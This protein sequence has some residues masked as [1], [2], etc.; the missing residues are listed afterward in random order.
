MAEDSVTVKRVYNGYTAVNKI[1]IMKDDING[2]F[3]YI[4]YNDA[5]SNAMYCFDKQK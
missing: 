4:V 3:C 5:G 1:Y 2:K